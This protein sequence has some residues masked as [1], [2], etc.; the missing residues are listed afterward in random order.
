MTIKLS[1]RALR[2]IKKKGLDVVAEENGV[3][4]YALPYSDVSE[5]RL[6]WKAANPAS[7]PMAKN[8][9]CDDMLFAVCSATVN[10]QRGAFC[11]TEFSYHNSFVSITAF[12]WITG[13]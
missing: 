9:R 8:P 3:D 13:Q 5:A 11:V 10:G 1:V 6:Q 2:T 4:L 12:M 7:P